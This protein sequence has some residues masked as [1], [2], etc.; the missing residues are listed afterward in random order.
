[1]RKKVCKEFF[2]QG[3][4]ENFKFGNISNKL[5]NREITSIEDSQIGFIDFV[6]LPFVLSFVSVFT[7]RLNAY[8]YRQYITRHSIKMYK[9]LPFFPLPS[10]N[11]MLLI[12]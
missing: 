2:Q 10:L 7:L 6:V 11:N 12:S 1:M 3:D 9:H 5:L 8:F 4:M